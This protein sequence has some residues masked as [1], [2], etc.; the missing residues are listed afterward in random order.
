MKRVSLF[1]LLLISFQLCGQESVADLLTKKGAGKNTFAIII[2]NEDYQSYSR[3]YVENEELAI[4][5]AE[6]FEQ[7]KIT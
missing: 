7:M 4:Y 2:A 6:R 5:Q 3:T 1:L